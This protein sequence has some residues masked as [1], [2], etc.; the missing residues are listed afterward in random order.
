[1]GVRVEGIYR[2]GRGGWGG[3]WLCDASSIPSVW[4]VVC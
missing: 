3:R 1:V 4:L 2:E